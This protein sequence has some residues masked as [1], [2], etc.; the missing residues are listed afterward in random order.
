[1]ELG[2]Q[3]YNIRGALNGKPTA[4]LALYQLPGSNSIDTANRVKGLME[5]MRSRFP[6][7]LDYVVSL[8]TTLAVSQGIHEIQHTLIIALVLVSVVVFVFL[9]GWRASIIPLLAVPVSLIGTFTFFPLFGF[10]I[11]TL[12]LLGLVL[13]IGLVVDDAIIV[14]EAT[15]RHIEEG[16]HPKEAA[17][18]A[19][20][21]VAGPVVALAMILAAVFV[22][23]VFIAGITGRLYQ[24]FAVTIAISVALSAFNALSLSPAL[25]ALLLKPEGK[26]PKHSPLQRFYDWFNSLFGKTRERYL[27]VSA[28]IIRR[29]AWVVV[30][31]VLIAA[32]AV[33]LAER[34]PKA[35]VPEEDQ[36]YAFAMAQLPSAASL[37]RTHEV[38][39]RIENILT[40]TPGVKYYTTV[41]GFSLLSQV[42]ATYN[43]FFFLGG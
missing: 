18:K 30:A 2:A 27:L 10:S 20:D 4:V 43:A 40:N 12:S 3:I 7:N 36:G 21:E 16:L 38:A 11:N 1:V 34:L 37:E 39:R 42:T 6:A 14:V 5:Q 26:R 28:A 17:V 33:L 35:F 29:S 25:A 24:Q 22:P 15:Q 8:D 9:Q 32:G 13:A 19:M 41:E 31:L 23:T